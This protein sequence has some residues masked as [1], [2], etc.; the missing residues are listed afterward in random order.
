MEGKRF[1]RRNNEDRPGETCTDQHR[2]RGR[3]LFNDKFG[4]AKLPREMPRADRPCSPHIRRCRA[5]PCQTRSHRV[6]RIASSEPR[7]SLLTGCLPL[8]IRLNRRRCN[9]TKIA[10]RGSPARSRVSASGTARAAIPR[11]VV[12]TGAGPSSSPAGLNDGRRDGSGCHP[13]L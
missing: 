13:G 1:Q 12:R 6:L 10:Q 9:V 4:I 7:V 5:Q 11:P 2:P 3:R 8:P